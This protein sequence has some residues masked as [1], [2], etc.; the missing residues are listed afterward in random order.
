MEI[1]GK[2]LAREIIEKLKEE[3]KDFDKLILA[4]FLIG[5]TEE[6]KKFLQEKERVAK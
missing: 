1:N 6:K 5:E 4:I 3:R 2:E